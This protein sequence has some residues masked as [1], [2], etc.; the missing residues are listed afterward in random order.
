MVRALF[1]GKLSSGKEGAQKS[2]SQLCLLAEDEGLKGPCP[3]SSVASAT[4]VL[5]RDP[6]VL[7]MLGALR[8][9]ES[10]GDLGPSAG[11]ALKMAWGWP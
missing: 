10:S 5:S 7:G 6:K 8:C 9:G 11:F 2:G 1:S 4:Y 3:R